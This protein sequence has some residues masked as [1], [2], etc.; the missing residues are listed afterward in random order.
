M[1]RKEAWLCLFAQLVG[2]HHPGGVAGTGWGGERFSS[3]STWMLCARCVSFPFVK[4]KTLVT[5]CACCKMPVNC[6]NKKPF[7]CSYARSLKLALVFLAQ[8]LGPFDPPK[9]RVNFDM[10]KKYQKCVL[11]ILTPN[12]L[13]IINYCC[14]TVFY[15]INKVA[16]ISSGLYFVP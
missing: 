2:D 5:L 13:T 15:S 10:F 9:M 16:S 6:Y 1:W 3:G 7:L 8:I 11:C 12:H 14:P 4:G